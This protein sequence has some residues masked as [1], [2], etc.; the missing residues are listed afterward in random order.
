MA[1]QPSMWHSFKSIHTKT[2]I[3]GFI[4]KRHVA[5]NALKMNIRLGISSVNVK[6]RPLIDCCVTGILTPAAG[7]STQQLPGS[8]VVDGVLPAGHVLLVGRFILGARHGD[9]F[10]L[11]LFSWSQNVPF[12]LPK[13]MQK[14][15]RAM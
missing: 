3:G 13:K 2:F 9:V 4:P 10:F 5:I 15:Q 12:L 8:R 14:A 1:S 6:A 7:S 11:F